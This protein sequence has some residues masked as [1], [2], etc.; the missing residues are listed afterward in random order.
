MKQRMLEAYAEHLGG[1]IDRA[2]RELATTHD[3]FDTVCEDF[4]GISD[5]TAISLTTD[6]STYEEYDCFCDCDGW[7]LDFSDWNTQIC[8]YESFSDAVTACFGSDTLDDCEDACSTGN[9]DAYWTYYDC[10]WSA[11]HKYLYSWG[12]CNDT[13]TDSWIIGPS[14]ET[15]SSG[16]VFYD[17]G[18]DDENYFLS[19]D[20]C[21]LL[22]GAAPSAGRKLFAAMVVANGL[23]VV[24]ASFVATTLL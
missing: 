3:G 21:D 12:L 16:C 18:S 15:D 6:F 23:L 13:L 7:K 4:N 9:G 20:A 11:Q 22:A 1:D 10:F 14:H 24:V 17:T 8:A 19:D 5:M 2:A